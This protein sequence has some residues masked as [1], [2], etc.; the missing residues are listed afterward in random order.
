MWLCDSI[1]LELPGAR[2]LIYGSD[3]HLHNSHSFQDFE[4]LGG[5][6][7]ENLQI[8]SSGKEVGPMTGLFFK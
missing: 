7:R 2:V 3:T 6:F 5:T 4:A 8:I 1:P